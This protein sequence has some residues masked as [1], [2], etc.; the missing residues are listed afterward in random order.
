MINEN[1]NISIKSLRTQFNMIS[2]E[3]TKITALLKENDAKH[4]EVVAQLKDVIPLDSYLNKTYIVSRPYNFGP[5]KEINPIKMDNLNYVRF[6]DNVNGKLVYSKYY[7]NIQVTDL[8][9]VFKFIGQFQDIEK[10]SHVEN[11]NDFFRPGHFVVFT[12]HN[13]DGSIYE[14]IISHI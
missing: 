10:L 1:L 14:Y 11:F 3:K 5:L 6:I 7:P 13:K 4:Q 2:D 9:G 12:N 8:S